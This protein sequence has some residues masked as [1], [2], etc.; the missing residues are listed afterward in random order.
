MQKIPLLPTGFCVLAVVTVFAFRISKGLAW[1]LDFVIW[2]LVGGIAT[3]QQV[4]ARNDKKEIPRN[5]AL[6]M[7]LRV[8]Q[9][10]DEAI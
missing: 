1:S 7:S 4:G 3:P 2:N 9:E 8:L 10:K 6:I 5:D